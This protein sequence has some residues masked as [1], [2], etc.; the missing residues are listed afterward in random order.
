MLSVIFY[1]GCT[2]LILSLSVI[3]PIFVA[4]LT[5]ELDEARRFAIYMLLGSFLFGGP[6]LAT[7]QRLNRTDQF[8]NLVLMFLVWTLLPLAASVPIMDISQLSFVNALFEAVSGLTTS[9]ASVL[10]QVENWPQSLIFWR[11][12]LQWLG[13]Y[14]ALV[15]LILVLGPMGIGGLSTRNSVLGGKRG[16]ALGSTRVIHLVINIGLLYAT[17]TAACFLWLLLTGTRPFYA[18]TLSMTAV[19]TG[20]FLP[21]DNSL[22]EIVNS[23]G[24][25]AIGV[26]LSLGATSIFWQRA[27]VNF[28]FQEFL[29]HRESYF[30]LGLIIFIS[31]TFAVLL[32]ALTEGRD[33]QTV[34][35]AEA[36]LNAASL[37]STSGIESRPGVIPLLPLVVVLFV[38]LLGGSAFSTSGGLKHYRVGG[39]ISQSLSELD[40][41]IYPNIVLTSHFG[42]QR[43][44]IWLMKAMWS[45]FIAAMLTIL[46][47]TL[48]ITATGIQFEA[49]LTATIAAFSTAGPLYKATWTSAGEAAWPRYGE[50]T[51]VAKYTFMA[52]SLLGRLEVLSVLGLL[53]LRYWRSR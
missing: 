49:A 20:G 4:L 41:L 48:L 8:S 44:D 22:D 36:F 13:G 17:L 33:I 9:G 46:V 31:A 28:R 38:V 32:A 11:I 19:S 25:V 6:L 16:F 7:L 21:F 12:Q 23:V 26:F 3:G 15:T 37:V 42:S 43:Y 53:S 10:T 27:L 50:F 47:G 40:R 35:L 45:F 29:H 18:A 52:V 30:V 51:T 5:G 2:G 39:M 1:L 14:L 34:L 24:L